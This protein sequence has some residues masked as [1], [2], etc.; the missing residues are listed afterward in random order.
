M[1]DKDSTPFEIPTARELIIERLTRNKW[2][3]K[4]YTD[5]SVPFSED[6]ESQELCKLIN[7]DWQDLDVS[8]IDEFLANKQDRCI[9]G[10]IL[11]F[12]DFRLKH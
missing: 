8:V 3:E 7:V 1:Y 10:E 11:T 4:E 5:L 9:T 2:F 6:F 12:K